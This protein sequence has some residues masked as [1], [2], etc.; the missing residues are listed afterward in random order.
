MKRKHEIHYK[1]P[2]KA[3]GIWHKPQ[4]FPFHF[5]LEKTELKLK[6]M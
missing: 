3:R 2:L 1:S 6:N 4:G 5:A